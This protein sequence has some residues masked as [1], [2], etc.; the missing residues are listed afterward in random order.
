M[1]KLK[2][3]IGKLFNALIL[4]LLINFTASS[5]NGPINFET[6]GFGASWTWTVFE[7]FPT[8]P[9]LTITANP[10][11]TGINPSSTVAKFNAL[12]TGNPWAGCETTHGA[13]IG[14][15]TLTPAN[16]VVK[17]MV[18]K[19][20]I[21]D[22]GIKFATPGNASTGEI[23]VANTLINQWEELTFN[24]TAV[25]NAPTSSGIDQIII[26]PDF[27]MN[28]SRTSNNICYFDNITFSS[29]TLS[30][31][32][33]SVAAPTP[34]AAQANVISLFSNTYT[35]VG[36]DTW[37]TNWSA[38]NTSTLQ[39][40]G[41]DT[42]LYSNLNF[43]GIETT[44][45]NLINA[46]C[47]THF[48]IDIYTPNMT[49]FR[50]KLVDWGA[51]GIYQGT[52]NDDTEAELSY[53]PTLNGW[54]T[55]NIPLSNFAS[56]GL[57]NKAHIAQIILSGNPAGN[58]VLYVDNIYFSKSNLQSNNVSICNGQSYTINPIGMTSFTVQGGSGSAIV[59]PTINT[60]YTVTGTNSLT[61]CSSNGI[62][63]LSVNPSPTISITGN[64]TIC[65]GEY[66]NLN[67]SG[68]NTYTWNNSWVANNISVT[69]S[70][71]TVFYVM[72]ANSNGCVGTASAQ[73]IV[74]E[75][76]GIN[77]FISQNE[78]QIYPNPNAGVFTINLKNCDNCFIK[79][80]NVLGQIIKTQKAEMLNDFN[81]KTFEKGIYFII[82]LNN[83]QPIYKGSIIK[84]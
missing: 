15:F 19:P 2:L 36:V 74:S 12:V 3:T 25:L 37:L 31:P 5:Q 30:N 28:P 34:T 80:T 7:N 11:P 83:N 38:G 48:N 46:N 77:S 68:A 66:V 43:V 73:I 33:P 70:T 13:G 17:M 71:S 32:T 59:S 79:I 14:T 42:R 27:K 72:G 18:Y 29:S 65:A 45:A 20:V 50:V 56:G 4:T 55:Y 52:P 76:T 26:F 54:N 57:V 82:I 62:I 53:T 64:Q 51:N 44:G 24:F 69:P 9:S 23:K 39:I 84:E 10:S 63:S 78:I 41:N 61:G 21:S 75:C 49:Q 47:M 81:I 67:A 60:T 16:C 58:G 22:V 40:A 8:N 35:N 1:I 6:P